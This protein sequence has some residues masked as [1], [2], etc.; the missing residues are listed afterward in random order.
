M[1]YWKVFVLCLI[2]QAGAFE[3][4]GQNDLGQNDLR[5][6][7]LVQSSLW[8]IDIGK[9][10]ARNEGYGLI[11]KIKEEYPNVHGEVEEYFKKYPESPLADII[12]FEYARL[13]FKNGNYSAANQAL[14]A[15]NI[16]SLEKQQQQEYIFKKGYCLLRC[17]DNALAQKNFIKIKGGKYHTPA[18]YYMGYIKYMEKEFGAAIPFFE[19][20]MQ[21][22]R[23][24]A[25]S[26]YHILES[27]FMLKDYSY[28]TSYGPQIYQN[29]PDEYKPQAAKILSESFFASNQPEKARYY[30][31]LYS[32][33][34]P[35][36]SGKDT[37]YSGMIAYTLKSYNEAIGLFEK[38]ASATDSIGQS[39]Y[40][41]IGECYFQL[42]NK[43][44]AQEA[45]KMAA[46]SSFDASIQEDAFFNYAKLSFDLNGNIAPFEE[47]LLKYPASNQKWDEIHSYMAASFL[48]G[49]EYEKAVNALKKIKTPSKENLS[50]LQKATFLRGLQLAESN[51]Y[52]MASN[53]FKDALHYVIQTGNTQLG[54]LANFWLAECRYRGNDFEGSLHILN[55]LTN[56]TTFKKSAEYPT[57]VYNTGYNHFKLG[58]YPAAIE[59]FATYL[60]IPSGSYSHEALLRLADSYFMNRNYSQA[61]ETYNQVAQ[62]ES[63][64]DLYA[65]LQSAVAYG[66]LS[67]ETKKIE[68]LTRISAPEY[69][70]KKLYSQALY[71]L[72]RTY[73]QN[74]KDKE[75]IDVLDQLINNPPDSIFYHKALLEVGMINANRQNFGEAL[76]YYKKII[77][78]NVITEEGQSALAGIENIYQQMNKQE[79][80]LEYLDN[81]GLSTV[82]NASEREI[83]LF[84]SAE[85]VFLSENYTAAINSLQSFLGKYP[86]GAKTTQA[87]FYLA[88]S[89]NKLGKAE[90]AAKEYMKVMMSESDAAFA[91]I[92]T[93]NYGRISFQLQRYEEAVRAFETLEQ[94]AKLG[95]NKSE[96]TIG[97]MRSY[98]NLQDW[99]AALVSSIQVLAIEGVQPAI[100]REATYIKAK[101]LLATEDR[102][103][104]SQLLAQLSLQPSDAIGAE[105]AYLLIL[106]AY[107]SGQFEKVE[108]LT[109]ALS[110]SGTPQTYW[111]A[112]SFITLGDSYAERDDLQQA[113]ATFE[114]IKENYSPQ[115]KDDVL[116][117]VEMRLKKILEKTK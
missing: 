47:Y 106:D 26:K 63:W 95:N 85:Q 52:T 24:A 18:L 21:D 1:R 67:D 75:A 25:A 29:L 105:A 58:N 30:N 45:F 108:E 66:L 20:A 72:G 92:A 10:N 27:K 116:S 91:E 117:Q 88:E 57:A 55:K 54:N 78:D 98:Y 61:A 23:F 115:S 74:S 15:V 69:A 71:E 89:Y 41:H 59:S 103:S 9:D 70:Q 90:A 14:E 2:L 87:T 51:S 34:A 100:K 94:I 60:A 81:I 17:G 68:I 50:N 86:T 99:R 113:K 5:Q 53:Y 13:N 37:F 43:H 97:K 3:V 32:T 56:N 65:P 110:D 93:L 46:Q 11:H 104:A 6:S 40:Y 7:G 82:K 112:K 16:K 39:A 84:N 111:L 36:I 35:N 73:V 62:L 49:Q 96:G 38:V 22:N 28:V 8:Q 107:D 42:K 79:E 83:M 101:T 19:Q 114:S 12:R 33:T 31:E 76:A 109:F 44:K 64:K 80:F 102:E 77:E 48:V 4:L